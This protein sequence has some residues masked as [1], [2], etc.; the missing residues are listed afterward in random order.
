MV[1]LL[2]AATIQASAQDRR[3]SPLPQPSERRLA[4]V[5]GNNAYPSAPLRNAVADATAVS[6]ALRGLQFDVTTVTD[7]DLTT[8]ERAVDAFVARLTPA[9]VAMFYF[10]GHGVQIDGENYLM[11][12]DFKGF[13]EIDVKHKAYSA[14]RVHEKLEARARVRILV[15]DACRDNPFKSSRS[16]QGGLAEMTARGS[17]IAFATSPGS[18]AS[19]NPRGRNGLFTEKLLEALSE[20]GLSASDLFR[21]VRKR[22]N[23]ASDGRQFPW[24]WDGLIGDFVFKGGARVAGAA[25][26]AVVSPPAREGPLEPTA[27]RNDARFVR[28]TGPQ[29]AVVA[30]AMRGDDA[31]AAFGLSL[32]PGSRFV[33]AGYESGVVKLWDPGTGQQVGV[34]SGQLGNVTAVALSPDGRHLAA[35]S[36]DHTVRLWDLDR[37]SEAQRLVGHSDSVWAVTFSPDGR[38]LAT[39]GSDASVRLWDVASGREKEV[40]NGH[41][42]WVTGLAFARDGR[43]LVSGGRDGVVRVWDPTTARE[44]MALEAGDPVWS[45]AVSRDLSLI[46]AGTGNGSIVAWDGD[47]GQVKWS[48]RAHTGIVWT[49]ALNPAGTWLASG[50]GDG[51]AQVRDA[52]SSRIVQTFR[53]HMNWV[54]GVA[55]DDTSSWLVSSGGD[56]DLRTWRLPK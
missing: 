22:V 26:P 53:G 11:P 38:T 34:L 42:D 55:F 3:L 15:L 8:L 4:L 28:P 16:A 10:S 25:A 5:V 17:L 29:R 51:V 36:G 40:L 48:S 24:L 46:V 45:V 27:S 49:L 35:T 7:A 31:G 54:R 23:D 12:V 52:S 6:A 32:S 39:G 43:A 21:Q 13:D 41:R 47:T 18:T 33:A 2:A 56:G 50:G 9:D 20:P 44:T 19:D 30:R 1:A 14:T 37:S